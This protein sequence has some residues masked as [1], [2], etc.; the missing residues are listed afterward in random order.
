M[1]L[2]EH[3]TRAIDMC[4]D[5]LRRGNKRIILAAPCSFGKTR[6]AV[7]ILASAAR[8]GKQGIFICD[9][10][11]LVQQTLDEFDLHG[12]EAGVIQGWEHPRS[13]WQSPIQIASIQTLARRKRWPMSEIV[14]VD[15]A[16]IHYKTMTTMMDKYSAIPFIGLSA[17]PFSKGLGNHYQDLIMPISPKE[18]TDKGFL[19]PA[20]YY[21]GSKP[22]LK[23]LKTR[24]LSTGGSDF[25]PLKLAERMEKDTKLAGDIIINWRKHGENSQTIA[26]SPSINHSKTLVRMFIEAGIPAQHIDGYMPDEER[27]ILYREHDEGKFKILS[28]SKLLNTGYDAPSVRCL[29][30]AFPTKSITSY[31]QRIGRVLRIHKDKPNAIILDHAGNVARHGFAQD[32]IPDVLHTSDKEFKERQ[33]TKE[34]KEPKTMDCPQCY[35]VMVIPRCPCGYEVPKAELLKMDDQILTRI[36]K[37]FTLQEKGRWLYE[38][39]HHAYHKGY[40]DGWYKWA[41]RS[42]FGVWPNKIMPIQTEERMPEVQSHIKHL[43]IKRAKD[44]SR[45]Y[46]KVG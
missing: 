34:K 1:E 21:G 23:G 38:F 25:D 14:I 31:V 13:N 12:I 5:S 44:V 36:N 45:N 22:D 30:D 6:V 46:R 17:T 18:L 39:Q 10:I 40:K 19:A 9:R 43:Q 8:K 27:Q 32:V 41:Y 35:Q 7:E 3:Q 2:R 11:K 15:E 42:K 26:F 4:R 24:Q 33:Q 20:V 28:C 16:H 29:I 37:S